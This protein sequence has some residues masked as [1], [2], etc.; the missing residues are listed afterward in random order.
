MSLIQVDPIIFIL[1]LDGTIIGDCL[2]Q[3]LLSNLDSTLRSNGLKLKKNTILST[4][5]E[6]SSKLIRPYFIY[7]INTMKKHFQNCQFYIYTASEKTWANK[8][9]SM[10]EKNNDIQFNRPI[11]TR[12][13]CI[14]NSDG[15]YV[16]SVKKILPKIEKNNKG[17]QVN[18]ENILVIDN[19]PVFI[20]YIS[21]FILC[22]TYDFLHFCDLWQI[23]EK[24]HLQNKNVK[25]FMTQLILSNRVCKIYDNTETNP[26]LLEHKHKW[27]YKKYKKINQE[28]KSYLKDN[29]WKTITK[30]IITKHITSFNKNNVDIIRR[31]ITA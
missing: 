26:T 1:D 16:K 10:I 15:Q 28:N 4:C 20:D 2:Y 24:E 22:P 14:M 5:Y 18:I 8:E 23:I 25:E 6:S 29:F 31:H 17:K 11:F 9:I 7:F 13:D 27:L 30:V 3:L 19:N 21:N 12:S